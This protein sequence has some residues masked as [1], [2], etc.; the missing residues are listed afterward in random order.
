M[1]LCKDCEYRDAH[2]CI[3]PQNMSVDPV[4]GSR[5][6]T[7]IETCNGHR[8]GAFTSWLSCRISRLCGKEGR[9]FK[10]RKETT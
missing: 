3:A 2:K 8:N 6:A 4:D 10:Q 9:W 7:W 5:Y 1:K